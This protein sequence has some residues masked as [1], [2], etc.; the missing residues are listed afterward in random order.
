MGIDDVVDVVEAGR[1]LKSLPYVDETKVAVGGLSYGG[2][3]TLHSLT[4][5]PDEFCMGVNL[6]GIWDFAQWT[7]WIQ[8]R[9]GSQGGSF[10]NFFAGFPEENPHTYE[11]GSPYTYAKNLKR[12]LINLHGTADANVDFE[13]LDRIVLDCVKYGKNYEAYYYPKELH[14]FR[15][16]STWEDAFP[17]IEREFDKY[18]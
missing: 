15:W 18:M 16:R 11:V 8:S 10:V 7:R 4:Q 1:Y 6:A 3:M 2:Y 13:Q 17:K 12:P 14:M 9:R 5:F